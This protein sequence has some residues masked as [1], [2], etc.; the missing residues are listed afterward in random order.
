MERD[1]KSSG[2]SSNW[3]KKRK[4][5]TDGGRKMKI[6]VRKKSSGGRIRGE[7]GEG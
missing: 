4:M 6:R 2:F 1:L 7:T 5:E 3:K